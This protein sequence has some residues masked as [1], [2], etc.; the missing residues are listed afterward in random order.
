MRKAMR[1][2]LLMGVL[3]VAIAGCSTTPTAPP[4]VELPAS[5]VGDLE[6]EHWWTNFDEPALSALVDEALASN[7][8]LQ[9]AVA[10]IETARAQVKLASADLYPSLNF[11]LNAG[12]SR[13]TQVGSNPLPP[14]FAATG[15]DF[16]LGLS[17]SY[18]VDLWGKYRTATRAAQNDLLA[19]EFARETVRSVVAAE[20]AQTY[21]GLIAADAQLQ[22]LKDTL[23]LREQ[24]V[25]LQTDR[26]QAGVIG[27]YDLAQARAARDAVAADIA[28]AQR[29]VSQFESALAVLTGRSPRDVFTPRVEREPSLAK[30]LTVPTVH[31]G[32]PS[33]MLERR[34]DVRQLE[35][36]LVAASLRIDR[37]RA[38][39]F[40]S[41]SL[42]GAFGTESG[43]LSNLFSGPSLI[44]SLAA[45]L[46]Q[47][48]IGLKAIEANV[49]AQTARRQELVVNYVQ[50]VQSAFKDTHD[51]LAANQ[52]AR[53]ALAAETTRRQNLQQA[54]DL[55]D[56]RYK[57]GYS[58]YLEVLDAQRQLLQAQTQQILAARDVR[59]ALVDLAKALGGGWDYEHAVEPPT[60]AVAKPQ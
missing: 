10:R 39:Y 20:V 18:E 47:P 30:L 6:L 9:A 32:L 17:A 25:A 55:S 52:A 41:L 44:A 14:G 15:N 28:T 22:L 11:G 21:F 27:Q 40:P 34:P 23:G 45:G 13:A 36:E 26:E 19:T 48:L 7:L 16:R 59:L 5:T 29:A 8:D 4:A 51:A 1:K 49:D 2:T 54:Y 24:T 31:A 57:A 12:R 33:D 60:T 58:P 38:D 43:A 56:L 37:A 46:V 35:K 3:A 42:T 53:D 50:T